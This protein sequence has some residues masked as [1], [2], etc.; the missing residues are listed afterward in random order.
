[1]TGSGTFF[2]RA[3]WRGRWRAH[4]GLAVVVAIVVAAVLAALVAASRSEQAF[5][6]LRAETAGADVAVFV[7]P[8]EDQDPE[9]FDTAA[10]L[11]ETERAVAAIDGVESTAAEA[12]LFVRPVGRDDLYPD[13]N[14]FPRAPLRTRDTRAL[15]RPVMVAG[16]AV[17]PRRADEVVLSER[18]AQDLGVSV[19]DVLPLESMSDAWVDVAFNGGDPGPADGPKMR[20]TVVGLARSPADFGRYQGIMHFSPAFVARYGSG[21]RT[22]EHV[23]T[24]LATG[25]EPSPA[26][27]ARF[28]KVTGD[29]EVGPSIFADDG[30]TRDGLDTIARALRIVAIVAAVAGAVVVMLA[31]ARLARLTFRDHAALRAL[32]WTRG[33]FVS[34]AILAFG[35]ALLVGVAAGLVLGTVLAPRALVGL[36]GRVDPHPDRVLVNGGVVLLV[37][38]GAIVLGLVAA[39]LAGHRSRRV[40]TRR[41][42]PVPR[43]LRLDRP[44]PGVLGVRRALTGE[45]ELGGRTSRGAT[46]VL[47]LA[48][49]GAVAALVVSASIARLQADPSLSGQGGDGRELDS[50]ESL[51]QYEAAL[52]LLEADNR[53]AWILGYHA[54]LAVRAGGERIPI[55][56]FDRAKG[57][58]DEVGV[59]SGRLPRGTGE[60]ALGPAT[61][62]SLGLHVGDRVQLANEGRRASYRVSGTTLFPEGDFAYDEGAAMTVAAAERML[63]GATAAEASSIHLIDFNW[64]DGVNA[65]RADRELEAAGFTLFTSDDGAALMPARVS[66]LGEV[67]RVPRYLAAFLGLLALVTL[68]HALATSARRRARETATLRALGLSRR[69]GVAILVVQAA[70]IVLVGLVV[71]VPVGLLLGDRIWTVIAEG[72]HVVV[73]TIAPMAGIAAFVAAIV[74]LAA[75]ATVGP[76]W[77]TA[78]LRPGEALR[79]E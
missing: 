68:A 38:L 67:E 3:E 48:V 33:Q 61:L 46:V 22:Y 8:D 55:L 20:P 59:V 63:D 56:A 75:V 10:A 73:E 53:V 12:E 14:L 26:M 11:G 79:A 18:F 76:A 66:N 39:A 65:R 21:M 19:G 41:T 5:T 36:A 60:V 50:G 34:T 27:K 44:L 69:G 28:D 40:E 43:L 54:G 30:A 35:P 74:V 42:R 6:R 57:R 62:E 77:R 72:A 58:I 45:S 78:R 17:D 64:A 49:T 25:G 2:A 9:T 51:D 32:G 13:Y 16:R 71:G 37:G 15:N 24:K 23:E 52:P 29:D 4:L 7:G 47:A 70:T 1:V 31:V